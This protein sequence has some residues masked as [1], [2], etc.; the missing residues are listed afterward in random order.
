MD[1]LGTDLEVTLPGAAAR[2]DTPS[3]AEEDL[4]LFS[5]PAALGVASVPEGWFMASA[6][7][8]PEDDSGCVQAVVS[9]G[10]ETDD[11]YLEVHTIDAACLTDDDTTDGDP[12]EVGG[13]S[14]VSNQDDDV[15]S[16]T[17]V[18]GEVGLGFETT[19]APASTQRL[20]E[21]VVAFDPEDDPTHIHI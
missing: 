9:Y 2:D 13:F 1:D 7:V 8:V 12:L 11:E 18:S 15:Y 10:G 14:G 19:L 16:G 6:Y 5:D 3:I 20:L 21:T 17:L 4:A